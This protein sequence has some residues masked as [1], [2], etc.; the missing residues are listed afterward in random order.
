MT[1][2]NVENGVDGYMHLV[3][4]DET[5]EK[6]KGFVLPGKKARQEIT[7]AGTWFEIPGIGEPPI[8]LKIK[9]SPLSQQ[10]ETRKQYRVQKFD[11][12][13]HKPYWFTDE[14][15]M[16]DVNEGMIRNA[17]TDWE[18]I[19]DG[20]TGQPLP[21]TPENL[22][23]F[24]DYCGAIDTAEYDSEEGDYKSVTAWIVERMTKADYHYGEKK[25]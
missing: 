23:A 9:F 17:I 5:A 20:D 12:K 11:K 4:P 16:Q 6:P 1:Q 15:K 10:K 13:T 19:N 21:F 14:E 7:S 8:R 3:G 2:Q 22:S 25:N 18:N 24:L